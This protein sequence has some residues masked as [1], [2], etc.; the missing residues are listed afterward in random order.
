MIADHLALGALLV[1]RIRDRVADLPLVEQLHDVDAIEER[2][3]ARR[4]G[5]IVVY[6]GDRLGETAGR[7]AAQIVHQR[8]LVVLAVRN[9]R[10]A[11]TGEGARAQA[12]PLITALLTALQGWQ[13]G[14]DHRPLVRVAAPAPGY[15]PAFAYYPLAFEAPISVIGA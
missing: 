13:P 14:A 15:S 8:W 5:A 4:A 2:L 12:G 7:G 1:A 11:D 9:A 6:D 3:N 10:G